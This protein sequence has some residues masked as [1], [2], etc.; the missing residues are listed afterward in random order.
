MTGEIWTSE[1]VHRAGMSETPRCIHCGH[2]RG[3]VEHTLWHCLPFQTQR[4]CDPLLRKLVPDPM[5]LPSALR[6]MAWAPALM[7]DPTA[8]YW[9]RGTGD[10]DDMLAT[11]STGVMD[12]VEIR[13]ANCTM[14]A[15]AIE[16][17]YWQER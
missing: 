13:A 1:Q 7:A 17:G 11:R 2:E 4:E 15:Q 9:G 3:D 12:T 6:T 5:V 8:P 14:V 16:Q 10:A